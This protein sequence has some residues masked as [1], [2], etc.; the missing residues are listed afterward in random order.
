EL[1]APLAEVPRL[2]AA[3]RRT[4][5]APDSLLWRPGG[6]GGEGG[7]GVAGGGGRGARAGGGA[8]GGG[9]GRGGD[10]VRPGDGEPDE[11][12]GGVVQRDGGAHLGRA[13]DGGLGAELGAE[14]GRRVPVRGPGPGL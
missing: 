13:V 10:P 9:A 14:P 1:A 6:R 4:T 11:R 7:G 3:Q 2:L 12:R 8:G 5:L